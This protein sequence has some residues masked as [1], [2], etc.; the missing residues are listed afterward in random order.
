MIR[1]CIIL[2]QFTKL[3][4]DFSFI[5]RHESMELKKNIFIPVLDLWICRRMLDIFDTKVAKYRETKLNV[6]R[7][8]LDLYSKKKE[9][10]SILVEIYGK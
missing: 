4:S 10:R 7:T 1:T 3:Y 6:K 2:A 8:G 9:T 5:L